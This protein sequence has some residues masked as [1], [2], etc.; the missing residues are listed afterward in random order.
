MIAASS[1][2]SDVSGHAT[3]PERCRCTWCDLPLPPAARHSSNREPVYCCYGCRFA[4]AVVQENGATGAL[5]WT[6]IRLGL[7]IFF[8]MNL[9]AFSMTMWS[10]DVYDIQPDPF[11][12]QLY[13][14]FRWL[15][16]LLALP[17]LLL[18]AVPLLQ[19]AVLR[20]PIHIASTDALIGV[21]VCAAYV[22][23][24]TSV[25]RGTGPIYFE[26][27]AMV[28]V[29]MT[30][31][32]WIEAM[33]RRRATETLDR[34][35]ALLPTTVTRLRP[36]ACKSVEETV[37][38]D[39][40]Q[41]GDDLH[42][43]AGERIAVDCCV[44]SGH[45]TVDEQTFTG[46]SR[47]VHKQP[48]AQLLAGTA[49]LDGDIVVQA[50]AAF[51]QGSFGR[52]LETLRQAR[53]S[54]GHYQQLADRT[55][56][57]FL[58][59]VA[60]LA[61]A[62]LLL[63]WSTGA[64]TALHVSMSVLLIACPCAL[65]L[66]TPLAVWS[67]LSVAAR[68]QILFRNGEAIERLAAVSAICL[69][70]TGTLTTGRPEVS[71]VLT[72]ESTAE[73]IPWQMIEQL[74]D[75][76]RHP[77]SQAI[78]AWVRNK[79]GASTEFESPLP[80]GSIRT[81]PGAGLE[82]T[83]TNGDHIRLGSIEFAG[84]GRK[85]PSTSA[86]RVTGTT[87]TRVRRAVEM[88][89]SAA[90]KPTAIV[91]WNQQLRDLAGHTQTSPVVVTRNGRPMIGFLITETLRDNATAVVRQL[92]A[93]P[94]PVY[95]LSGD[96][97][98]RA[99]ALAAQLDAPGLVVEGGLQPH[100]KTNHVHRIRR[101]HGTTAM[102]GDGIND[103]PALAASDVGIAMG[104]GA[105]VSRDSADICLLGD[106]IQRIPWAINLARRTRRVIRQNLAWTFG[107][108]TFGLAAAAAGWLNPAV[109]AG[110]M[111]VSSLMVISNSL[112]LLH[113]GSFVEPGTEGIQT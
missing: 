23:S 16:M 40:I 87:T 45:T 86:V 111:I 104:C 31:G 70:K 17:V 106:H 36:S 73:D 49:N 25:V 54:H 18:L 30:L 96:Q 37:S 68:E 66:A 113:T 21:A 4:H 62:C 76:S 11:Q 39:S 80:A 33:G 82:T 78:A 93:D 63:H 5:R 34:M 100:E 9:M 61:I 72:F 99:A 105:D 74:A 35:L 13:E 108:N 26:V 64:A 46:E 88:T 50:T 77:Y 97:P 101:R 41:P 28:L 102:V 91:D 24:A 44:V 6:V 43:R 38:S 84:T 42:I 27:G 98:A 65:G 95:V 29:M 47:P 56:A 48:G 19:N 75:A 71:R 7:A 58:P 57:W 10:L 22:T 112:R 8:T 109:A 67:A 69:D 79:D 59:F 92:Q 107:Y 52:L 2:A 94:L 51:R 110:L 85:R 1:S 89:P 103:A 55:A 15:S 90:L 12:Q 81:I 20:W 14:V 83:T 60:A 3:Q 32:R 53:L